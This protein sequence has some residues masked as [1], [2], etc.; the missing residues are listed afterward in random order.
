[1]RLKRATF[2]E[3]ALTLALLLVAILVGLHS[4]TGSA[5][6]GTWCSGTS[7]VT[8]TNGDAIMELNARECK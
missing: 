2:K 4:R 7:R 6:T 5:T 3:V 8:V 1:M